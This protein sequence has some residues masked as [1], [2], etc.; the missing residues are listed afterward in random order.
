MSERPR[1]MNAALIEALGIIGE[2]PGSFADLLVALGDVANDK[3]RT[4]QR[5]VAGSQDIPGPVNAILQLLVLM[6]DNAEITPATVR[7]WLE[8]A[9]DED[10]S[11]I[12]I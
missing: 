4:V 11:P 2:T 1:M 10:D 8:Q 3:H 5:W 9:Y 7:E 6:Q 12:P